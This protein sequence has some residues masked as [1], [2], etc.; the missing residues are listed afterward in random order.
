[1]DGFKMNGEVKTTNL[2]KSQDADLCP[3]QTRFYEGFMAYLMVIC[4]LFT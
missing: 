4:V 2:D 1:M 3:S